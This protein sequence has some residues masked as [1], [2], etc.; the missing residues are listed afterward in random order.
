MKEKKTLIELAFSFYA[1]IISTFAFLLLFSLIIVYNYE[2]FFLTSMIN[3][4]W[5]IIQEYSPMP[6]MFS[7]SKTLSISLLFFPTPIPLDGQNHP[8]F[9]FQYCKKYPPIILQSTKILI[10]IS[11][12]YSKYMQHI[13]T[14]YLKLLPT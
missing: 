2:W 7:I 9:T 1:K 10:I 3:Y 11:T 12:K 5:L 14:K 8:Q 13:S 4:W 6:S